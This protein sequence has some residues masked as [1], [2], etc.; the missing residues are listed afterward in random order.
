MNCKCWTVEQNTT[1]L[2]QAPPTLC[3]LLKEK[4]VIYIFPSNERKLGNSATRK[5][6]FIL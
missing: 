5:K 4:A 3:V 1:R 2:K 6:I